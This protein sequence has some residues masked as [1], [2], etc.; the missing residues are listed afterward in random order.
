MSK[1]SKSKVIVLTLLHEKTTVAEVAKRFKISRVWVYQLLK[2]YNEDG[3]QGLEPRSKRPHGNA[4]AIN[5]QV[6]GEIIRLRVHLG[7]SG[8]DHGPETIAWHLRKNGY[9]PPARSTISRVLYQAG[10]ITPEPKKR[11]KSY[12]Q[13]FAAYQPNETWQSDF[14]HWQLKDGSDVEILNWLD[15]HSRFLLYSSAMNPVR[16]GDVVRSFQVC[17]NEYGTPTSTLTDNGIV[18]TARFVGGRNAFEYLLQRLGIKQKNGHPGHPQTQG[19]IERFHRTLKQWLKW[20]P[21]VENI[22]QLQ[23]QLNQFRQIYNQERPHRAIGL[24]TPAFAYSATVKAVPPSTT[25]GGH[26]RVRFDRVDKFGKV[27]LRRAGKMH[28]L[29]VGIAHAGKAVTILVDEVEVMVIDQI[30]G[31]IISKHRI[32]PDKNYWPKI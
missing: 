1:S 31:E 24:K 29:R 11:P 27:S 15:D 30:S 12:I 17:I 22:D 19:K 25:L 10:L 9:L 21:L 6:R 32:R 14:T 4:L 28:H 7:Q 8:L 23:L 16:G 5:E 13:R 20:Q 18:Y 26:Y 2:R 3:F